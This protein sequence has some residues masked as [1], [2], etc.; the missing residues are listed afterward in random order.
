[1]GSGVLLGIIYAIIK[2]VALV[3]LLGYVIWEIVRYGRKR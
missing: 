1:M 2:I 3:A